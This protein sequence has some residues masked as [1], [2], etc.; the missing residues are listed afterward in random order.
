MSSYRRNVFK[1]VLEHKNMNESM[2][3]EKLEEGWLHC[4][5]IV[6]IVGKPAEHVKKSLDLLLEKLSKE[7]NVHVT[8]KKSHPP[9]ENEGFF[10]AFAEIEVIVKDTQTLVL[11][12]FD[13]LPSSVELL[14]PQEIDMNA[15]ALSDLLNDL[16]AQLHQVGL[17]LKNTN[18]S[19]D[20]LNN[21]IYNLMK[22]FIANLVDDKGAEASFLA[23]KI[24]IEE[25]KLSLFLKQM[26]EEK[27][28]EEKDGKYFMKN[29]RKH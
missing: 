7:K 18:L 10:T 5:I 23:S 1:Y 6:E 11:L 9:K 28:L 21:N 3:R 26:K 13:Y 4:A 15:I 12:C 25:K 19:I 22:N 20:V 17:R 16:L 24:G 14:A 29:V 8:E 27:Y 2:L